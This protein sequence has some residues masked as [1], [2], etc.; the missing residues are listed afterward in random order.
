MDT[1]EQLIQGIKALAKGGMPEEYMLAKVLTVVDDQG[2]C[3]VENLDGLRIYDVRLTAQ[4]P[5]PDDSLLIIPEVGSWVGC[6]P[7]GQS[8]WIVVNHSTVA[9][10]KLRIGTAYIAVA[11]DGIWIEKGESLKTLIGDLIA[12]IKLITVTTP[13]GPSTLPLL[14]AAAFDALKTRFDNVLK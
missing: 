2:T 10:L 13:S 1:K 6:V 7:F 12:Q 4:V 5:P 9:G 14:N 3:D 11:A 8:G